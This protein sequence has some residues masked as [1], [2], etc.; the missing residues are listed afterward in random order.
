MRNLFL[1]LTSSAVSAPD[2]SVCY[3]TNLFSFVLP[4][5]CMLWQS[6]TLPQSAC[7]MLS[8]WK[9]DLYPRAKL[10]IDFGQWGGYCG[11]RTISRLCSTYDMLF[12][13]AVCGMVQATVLFSLPWISFHG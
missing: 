5:S 2:S 6:V 13:S 1:A 8:I 4:L 7:K 11:T 3:C 9:G 12:V 10:Y